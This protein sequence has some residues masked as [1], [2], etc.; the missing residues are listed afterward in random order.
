MAAAKTEAAQ[1]A[2]MEA[3]GEAPLPPGWKQQVT[4]DG[5]VYYFNTKTRESSYTRP[6]AQPHQAPIATP[7][8]PAPAAAASKKAVARKRIG[9]TK[10]FVVR[11]SDNSLFYFNKATKKSAYTLPD[12]LKAEAIPQLE[13]VAVAEEPAAKK[14]KQDD[15]HT[16]LLPNPALLP[17]GPSTQQ[18][19]QLATPQQAPPPPPPPHMM[20]H[21]PPRPPMPPPPHLQQQQQMQQQMQQHMQQQPN[22]PPR[23]PMPPAPPPPPHG[24]PPP[25]QPGWRPGAPPHA[26]PPPPPHHHHHHH[27]HR[28]PPPHHRPPYPPHPHAFRPPPHLHYH[29]HHHQ[30]QQPAKPKGPSLADKQNEFKKVLAARNVSAFA[31]WDTIR[32]EVEDEPS[33]KALTEKQAKSAFNKYQ[34]SKLE[35][36]KSA[37]MSKAAETKKAFRELMEEANVDEKTTWISFKT[38]WQED[39]RFKAIGK[40]KEREAAFRE[41][42]E[43]L[44]EKDRTKAKQ[45]ET[46][47]KAAFA[48]YEDLRVTRRDSF[49]ALRRRIREDERCKDIDEADLEA[50]FW[51]Y[52][53]KLGSGGVSAIQQR[54]AAVAEE[55]RRLE[56][57]MQRASRNLQRGEGRDTF[58][59]L[60]ANKIRSHQVSWEDAVPAMEGDPLWSMVHLSDADKQQLFHEHQAALRARA[61]AGYAAALDTVLEKY[62]DDITF[63][64]VPPIIEGDPRVT[65]F[66]SS[67]EELETEFNRYVIERKERLVE[68]FKALLRETKCITHKS[69]EK[70]KEHMVDSPHMKEIQD[71]LE[72]D[73]RYHLL[74][75]DP[76]TRAQLLVDYMQELQ[77]RGTPPPP[78]ASNPNEEQR[79]DVTAL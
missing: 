31:L 47:K 25:Y 40:E 58:N 9:K 38:R 4:P 23:P 29:H 71:Y 56:R 69:W 78:T 68:D 24:A 22:L 43:E 66:S 16:G 60:L 51:E 2:K 46:N 44:H 73:K 42:V 8:A 39:S 14:A 21:M 74:E 7:T 5:Q 54:E 13:E 75:N 18:P 62:G 28:P 57:D 34:S 15:G 19:H 59:T 50:W 49:R 20:Q 1:L 32:M 26:R 77:R 76:T 33:F 65:N 79:P 55:R 3:G 45:R 53:D 30:Q 36:E 64:D 37:V 61:R 63:E 41:Y 11:A 10:W 70:V 12:E 72:H 17:T 48:A 52:Q 67:H 27:H 6:T 35:E